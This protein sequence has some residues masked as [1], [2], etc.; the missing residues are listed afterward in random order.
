MAVFNYN[1]I[2]IENLIKLKNSKGLLTI[3][4]EE[5]EKT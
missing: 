3:E 1:K 2:K 4:K 5:K